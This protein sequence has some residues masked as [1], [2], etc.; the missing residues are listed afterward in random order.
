MKKIM[1]KNISK[2]LLVV[3]FM[4]NAYSNELSSLEILHQ[5]LNKPIAG[6]HQGGLF[7]PYPNTLPAFNK[8]YISGA[9]V[10]EMDLHLTKDGV[11]VVYHDLELGRW[12]KCKGRIHEKTYD[13]IKDCRF[14]LSSIARIPKFEEVLSW[15]NGKVIIDA[16]FKDM[17]S[18]KPAIKL[19]QKYNAYSWSYFQAQ[20]NRDKYTIAH[21][22]DPQIALLYA[23]KDTGDDLDWALSQSNS[24]M[25]IEVEAKTRN[26]SVI[27]RIH[28]SG[29]LV[30]ED[31]WHFSKTKELFSSSCKKAFD[32]H[33]EI[34]V[35]NRPDGCAKEK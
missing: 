15:S 34:A 12:T 17:E 8:A 7:G 30:T 13:E 2:L 27:D 25:I 4:G 5:K 19:I 28:A 14:K 29:K 9:D 23:I 22:F 32:Q 6:A 18:I 35:S 24:L 20:G 3:F 26:E 10:I 16:E 1:I 33:I 31:S 11:V 21:E